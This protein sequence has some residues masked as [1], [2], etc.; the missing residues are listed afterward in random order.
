[1]CLFIALALACFAFFA[2]CAPQPE[3]AGEGGQNNEQG[4]EGEQGNEESEPTPQEQ[5]EDFVAAVESDTQKYRLVL[6]VRFTVGGEES[7]AAI[8][9]S[10][11]GSLYSSAVTVDDLS[12]SQYAMI[13]GDYTYVYL[14]ME[15]SGEMQIH[16]RDET[17]PGILNAFNK[18][19]EGLFPGVEEPLWDIVKDGMSADEEGIAFSSGYFS[20]GTVV[21]EEE[22]ATISLS[23][24]IELSSDTQDSISLE[25]VIEDLGANEEVSVS[26]GAEEAFA[27]VTD[28]DR[29]YAR[30]EWGLDADNAA[31]SG[32]LSF[33]PA[34]TLESA[35]LTA[36]LC[37]GEM[38]LRIGEIYEDAVM[39]DPVGGFCKL[40]FNAFRTSY[41]PAGKYYEVTEDE[42]AAAVQTVF[43]V[44]AFTYVEKEYYQL[45]DGTD[46][47]L[48][49]SEAGKDWYVYCESL[50]I[51]CNED[52]TFDISASVDG[53]AFVMYVTSVELTVSGIGEQ[54][55]VAFP[56]DV[57]QSY[58]E[59]FS[60]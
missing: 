54:K 32:T 26:E 55:E 11:N 49:L 40:N 57:K 24:P 6:T 46:N 52:G 47:V 13:D 20:E 5:L 50:E 21:L 33:A 17:S 2:A 28:F 15:G 30:F 9:V 12:Y 53:S 25:A 18:L 16:Y 41:A 22:R 23:A 31:V 44:L 43:G 48:T 7:V 8:S 42:P 35:R 34:I 39:K 29:A 38:M 10:C 19:T 36:T 45:K 58:E 37:G 1:M 14:E 59:H 4:N 51:V 27:S 56:D 3:N 60:A